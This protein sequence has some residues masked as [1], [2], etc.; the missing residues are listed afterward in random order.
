MTPPLDF[1]PQK[2]ALRAFLQAEGVDPRRL[3]V[4]G[5]LPSDTHLTTKRAQARLF[6][7]SL[8]YN[9]HR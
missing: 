2:E 9:A 5:M 8:E 4:S 3:V 6:L 7:D 1:G